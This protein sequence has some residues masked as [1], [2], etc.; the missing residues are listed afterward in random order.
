MKNRHL[1]SYTHSQW[2][3]V[4][5][6]TTGQ[7]T[8]ILMLSEYWRSIIDTGPI[9]KQHRDNRWAII[10]RLLSYLSVLLEGGSE[11]HK[12]KKMFIQ[13]N[14]GTFFY[15]NLVGVA[16]VLLAMNGVMGNLYLS[17]WLASWSKDWNRLRGAQ[18]NKFP[19]MI[20]DYQ[21]MSC[22]MRKR[23]S[24]TA[25]CSSKQLL[26]SGFEEQY[27]QFTNK[28]WMISLHFK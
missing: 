20:H 1:S 21:V 25:Y 11:T 15:H 7:C 12:Q 26:P 9:V 27:C 13:T 4:S 28:P 2:Y 3:T 17:V 5:E 19:V 16:T 6:S 24:V 22:Y 18:C 14:V 23:K 10:S 8:L